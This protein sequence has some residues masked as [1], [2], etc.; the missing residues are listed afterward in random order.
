MMQKTLMSVSSQQH[1]LKSH[2]KV[3]FLGF[4]IDNLTMSETIQQ[5]GKIIRKREICQ[6]VVVNA[7]KVVQAHKDPNL[8]A[9]INNCQLVNADGQAIIWASRLLGQPLK[10]R[11]AGIDLMINLLAAANDN[12]WRVFCLGATREVNKQMQK[13]IK[14]QF[15]GLQI[16]GYHGYFTE[17]EEE[18]LVNKIKHMNIDILFLGISSPKK[19]Y[20]INKYLTDMN[21]PFCM[22]VGG[23]FDVVAG[24]T[25]R[26]P[27]WM[28]QIGFEWLYR[29][30]QEPK[31]IGLRKLQRNPM[32]I[33]MIAKE[34]VRLLSNSKY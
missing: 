18:E 8:K 13:K 7:E 12:Q 11:V 32:F 4:K 2:Q 19:E 14:D 10:E 28:Q 29:A 21:V 33:Y 17:T 5:I 20:F 31:R 26:A 6:H 30:Y 15:P 27:L 9:I 23:S 25:K 16:E 1:S 3:D 22:G 34:K 24:K